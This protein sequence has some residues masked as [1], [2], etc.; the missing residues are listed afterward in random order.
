MYLVDAA[1]GTT[2]GQ[3]L[4][5]TVGTNGALQSLVGGV[6]NNTGTTANP[7]PMIV[8]HHSKFLYLDQPGTEPDSNQRRQ[9]GERIFH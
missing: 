4:P 1:N 7:G 2:P 8:D 6:V 5:Y 9:F 3:I